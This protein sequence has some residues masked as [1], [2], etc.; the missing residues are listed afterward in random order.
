MTGPTHAVVGAACAVPV[1]AATH[2]PLLPVVVAGAVVARLPD[3][4]LKLGLPHRG[5]TH[6]LAA[7]AVAAAVAAGVRVR[8]VWPGWALAAVLVVLVVWLSHLAADLV[9]PTPM[10][11]LW[12]L[13]WGRLRPGF[14]PAVREASLT[15]RVLEL[16]TLAAAVGLAGPVVWQTLRVSVRAIWPF[17]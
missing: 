8:Q 13:W 7:A 10:A 4:D 16:A 12:P 1:A 17:G 9:N 11:L 3:L 6:S 2:A 15:G 14:L 5:P